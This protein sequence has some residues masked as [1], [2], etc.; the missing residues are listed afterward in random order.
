MYL[1]NTHALGEGAVLLQSLG[2]VNVAT[3]DVNENKVLAHALTN[4][5]QLER[6]S[7]WAIKCSS[8][9]VNK[10]PRL[11]PGGER[12]DGS[13]KNP[14]HLLGCFPCLFPYGTGRFK[15]NRPSPVSYE[16]HAQ[17][18]IHYADRHFTKDL[19]FVFQ[20]FGVLQKQQLCAAASVA[21]GLSRCFLQLK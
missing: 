2:V 19:H 7:G 13:V 5:S 1:L 11:L 12:S 6:E 18:A 9:L 14:S 15:V 4:V 10:Y 3:M 20:V 8:E 17:W 21:A 16:T